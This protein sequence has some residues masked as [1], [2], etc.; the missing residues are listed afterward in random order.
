MLESPTGEFD[1]KFSENA[2][3]IWSILNENGSLKKEDILEKTKLQ[4]NDFYIGIGWLARENKIYRDEYS[5]YRLDNSN[6]TPDIGNNA[7]RIWKIID[8]WEEVELPTIKKLM[9]KNVEEVYSAIGWLAKENKI[10]IDEKQRLT[11]KENKMI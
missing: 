10:K 3:K 6:L 4:E 7:G 11:L 9:N 8:I 5:F 1:I 2:G